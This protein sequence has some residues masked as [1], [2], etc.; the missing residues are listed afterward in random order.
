[1]NDIELAKR[2][3][4]EIEAWLVASEQYIGQIR[5]A[6]MRVLQEVDAR[7]MPLADGC[8]SMAE[9]VAGRLDM[10]PQNARELA[11]TSRRLVDL[12]DIEEAAPDMSYDRTTAIARLATPDTQQ[13]VLEEMASWDISGV[14]RRAAA[15]RRLT[16]S[17]E[18]NIAADE[19]MVLRPN[20]DESRWDVWGTLGGYSGRIVDK[21]LTERG[22]ELPSPPPEM[23]MSI[24]RRKAEALISICH[25]SLDGAKGGSSSTPLVT[26]FVEAKAANETNGETGVFL[27]NGLRVGPDTLEQILCEGSVEILGRTEDGKPL[28]FFEA[29]RAIPPKLRRAVLARDQACCADGC[30]STYR[31]QPHHVYPYAITKRH[32]A[33]EL[34]CFCWWHH[35]CNIHQRGFRIDPSSPRNRTRFLPPEPDPP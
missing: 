11:T 24:G 23:R 34:R 3:S 18:R 19:H 30:D 16:R 4:D 7:Q 21:A 8:R 2:T 17:D 29:G 22:D 14:H 32:V 28:A 31:L 20:L 35:Q 25:D 5:A 6:Q 12:P 13:A 1:M 15:E 33:E 27:D 9:W 26:I 10:A